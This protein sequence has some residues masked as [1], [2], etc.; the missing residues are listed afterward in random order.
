MNWIV[1]LRASC[2]STPCLYGFWQA[3]A[4]ISSLHFMYITRKYRWRVVFNQVWKGAVLFKMDVEGERE[5]G[6]RRTAAYI[7]DWRESSSSR[8]RER[9]R[10]VPGS[11]REGALSLSRTG[12]NDSVEAHHT[13]PLLRPSS[14][15]YF[16]FAFPPHPVRHNPLVPSSSF[17]SL[18]SSLFLFLY[19]TSPLFLLGKK[20]KKKNATPPACSLQTGVINQTAL[21]AN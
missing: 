21:M 2:H 9:E 18:L 4:S 19:S 7:Y 17:F 3:G 10:R 8:E 5:K 13:S 11:S 6:G 16:I 15:S 20:G 14:F 12:A 1:I